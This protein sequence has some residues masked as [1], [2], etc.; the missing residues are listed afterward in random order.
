MEKMKYE[1]RESKRGEVNKGKRDKEKVR[2]HERERKTEEVR[3]RG[4]RKRD[5]QK[6]GQVDRQTNIC[7][8]AYAPHNAINHIRNL[9]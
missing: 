2:K 4:K 3:W 8:Q 6:G 5:R 9:L 7:L 1:R